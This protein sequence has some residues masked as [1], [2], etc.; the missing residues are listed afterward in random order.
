MT[1]RPSLVTGL[2]TQSVAMKNA[3]ST[4]PPDKTCM[5]GSPAK[6]PTCPRAGNTQVIR[7]TVARYAPGIFQ[8]MT[9]LQMRKIPPR[10]N[11][12]TDTSP[13][14]PAFKPRNRSK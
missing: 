2:V 8:S 10:S 9:F 11:K 1:M 12:K 13:K 3:P 6:K 4:N 7:A 5:R 14:L